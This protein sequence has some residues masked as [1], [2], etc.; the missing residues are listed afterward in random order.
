[1]DETSILSEK[2]GY[3]QDTC[4]QLLKIYTL[5]Q[6]LSIV[7]KENTYMS[8]EV[9]CKLLQKF[10]DD[11]FMETNLKENELTYMLNTS[12]D[13]KDIFIKR[14]KEAKMLM[15]QTDYS[16]ETCVDMLETKTVEECISIYMDIPVKVDKP[17][18]TNQGKFKVM[19]ELY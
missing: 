15:R 16:F 9:I 17:L 14:C 19:R 12:I 10:P 8:H 7:S 3:A 6:C 11:I 1:M 4:I 5:E 13:D 18:S 2:T